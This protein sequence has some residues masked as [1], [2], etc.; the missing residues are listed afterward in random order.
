MGGEAKPYTVQASI[1]AIREYLER[2]GIAA[3]V[4]EAEDGCGIRVRYALPEKKP[5]LSI[6]IPTHNG[7]A[8]IKKCVESIIAKTTYSPYEIIIVDSGSDD[9]ATLDYLSVLQKCK[10]AQVIRDDSPFNHSALN[11]RAVAQ[12]QG[13]VITLLSN[14]VEIINPDWAEEMVS[15]ALRPEIGAAGARLWCPDD[16]LQH[17]GIILA[18]D[19]I[20]FHAHKRIPRSNSGYVGRAA[21]MQNFSAVTASCLTVRKE[22]YQKVGGLDETMT[23]AYND[24]DFCLRVRE[25]GYRILWTPYAQMYRHESAPRGHEDSQEMQERLQAE[26]QLMKDRWGRLLYNDPAYNP[27]LTLE[28]EDFYLSFPPRLLK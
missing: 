15:H 23:V 18:G 27:N 16:T 28:R 21:L 20:A 22:V 4:S 19:R 10:A 14:D 26:A 5:L 13:S 11:N 17:A 3:S 1:N 8:L 24:V 6:I 7:L 25:K 2:R 12:A 9:P